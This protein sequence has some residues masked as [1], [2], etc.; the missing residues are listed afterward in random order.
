MAGLARNWRFL[1]RTMP[2]DAH[3]LHEDYQPPPATP[4][5]KINLEERFGLQ[6][7][8]GPGPAFLPDY[9]NWKSVRNKNIDNVSSLE[10][11]Y[12]NQQEM[13]ED[14]MQCESSVEPPPLPPR[15]T[16]GRRN[17]HFNTTINIDASTNIVPQSINT[18]ICAPPID[19][20]DY[21]NWHEQAM[22]MEDQEEECQGVRGALKY[23]SKSSSA[24]RQFSVFQP[25]SNLSHKRGNLNQTFAAGEDVYTNIT[26]ATPHKQSF[27]N[28]HSSIAPLWHRLHPEKENKINSGKFFKFGGH[29]LSQAVQGCRTAIASISQKFKTSTQRRYKL[30]PNSPRGS[31]YATPPRGSIRRTPGK[32]YSPFNCSTPPPPR[33]YE[34]KRL[35]HRPIRSGLEGRIMRT[36]QGR[37]LRSP[38]R[39]TRGNLSV[40]FSGDH[41][42]SV[43]SRLG[44]LSHAGTAGTSH[45]QP[46]MED[47]LE[48]RDP[49]PYP[50]QPLHRHQWSSFQSPHRVGG[51]GVV[52]SAYRPTDV[53]HRTAHSVDLL[54]EEPSAYK[55]HMVEFDQLSRNITVSLNRGSKFR[56]SIR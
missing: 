23:Q 27:K 49:P 2:D 3:Y 19:I 50:G 20:D 44:P 40:S 4:S 10:K 29:R 53:H 25:F 17:P 42:T 36:P 47:V 51:P 24:L 55:R 5:S 15:N 37:L 48:E 9:E 12:E 45:C 39:A 56:N 14:A 18:T 32:L 46:T 11:I 35:Q 30:D 38:G 26:E 16:P 21:N 8:S 13:L 34:T 54:G 33:G 52:P 6:N 31:S 43:H 1:Q 28:N 41:Q 7:A 22:L